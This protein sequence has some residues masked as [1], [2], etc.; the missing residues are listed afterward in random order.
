[1]HISHNILGQV[2]GILMFLQIIPYV[3]ST[4]KRKTIPQRTTYAI[5]TLVNIISA[6][7]YVSSGAIS[8]KWV[9]IVWALTS[10][11]VF[12]L[13]LKYGVGGENHLDIGCLV[14]AVLAL[15]LWTTTNNP[16]SALYTTMLAVVLG[17]VPTVKKS[18]EYPETENL[19]S[20]KL[21]G[22]A[23]LLNIL[24][25]EIWTLQ[26]ALLPIIYGFFDLLILTLLLRRD[27]K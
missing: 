8:T 2:A 6:A 9:S 25:V 18:F 14:L 12:L 13:S 27:K 3:V 7:S 10:C 11:L 19:T 21:V 16:V 1:M 26:I 4:I 5:W 17:Y 22:V 24:A 23:A 20:W 15:I